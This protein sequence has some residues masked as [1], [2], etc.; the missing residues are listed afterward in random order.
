MFLSFLSRRQQFSLTLLPPFESV[1]FIAGIR[2]YGV[3]RIGTFV[4]ANKCN[5]GCN[6]MEQ[7]K[8]LIVTKWN[9][10]FK[11]FNDLIYESYNITLRLYRDET[12]WMT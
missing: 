12:E 1:T 2:S 10:C 3:A 9:F 5:Y 6:V 11:K 7:Q 4:L 8:S